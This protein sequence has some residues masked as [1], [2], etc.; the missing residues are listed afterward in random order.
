MMILDR[1]TAVIIAIVFMLLSI[2]ISALYYYN[3][4]YM[5][6]NYLEQKLSETTQNYNKL[7]HLEQESEILSKFRQEIVD[8]K[9]LE[10]NSEMSAQDLEKLCSDLL[11]KKVIEFSYLYIKANVDYPILFEDSPVYYNVTLKIGGE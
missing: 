4:Y 10:I 2:L 11:S 5:Y 6:L 3:S 9:D 1:K 8:L 7:K